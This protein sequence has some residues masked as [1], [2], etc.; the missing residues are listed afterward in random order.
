[1]MIAVGDTLRQVAGKV[2]MTVVKDNVTRAVGNLKLRGVKMLGMK[3]KYIQCM[4]YL[5]QTKVN[6]S[7]LRIQKMHSIH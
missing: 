3:L 2:P 6:Q 7:Y 1:M 4:T 5:N